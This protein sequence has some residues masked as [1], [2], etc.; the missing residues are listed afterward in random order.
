VNLAAAGARGAVTQ[1]TA[2]D[3]FAANILPVV[4]QIQAADAATPRDRGGLE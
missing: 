2:A 3:A 4:R 1:R